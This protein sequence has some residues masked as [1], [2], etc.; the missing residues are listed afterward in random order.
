[1]PGF[2]VRV[3]SGISTRARNVPVCGSTVGLMREILPTKLCPARA[4]TTTSA[5]WPAA[6]LRYYFSGTCT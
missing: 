2:S 5:P 4:S 1:M 3:G 6:I